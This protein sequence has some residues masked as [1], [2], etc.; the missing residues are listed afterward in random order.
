GADELSPTSYLGTKAKHNLFRGGKQTSGLSAL[1]S[2]EG[3]SK[4]GDDVGPGIGRSGGVP[5]RVV[6]ALVWESMICGG[7]EWETGSGDDHRESGDGGGVGIAR[8]LA[9]SV[10]D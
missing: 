3:S 2:A 6:S 4:D 5:D 7:G 1:W 10:S 8:S 9:T